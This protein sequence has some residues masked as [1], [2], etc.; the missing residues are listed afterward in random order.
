MGESED[1][2]VL[3]LTV[4]NR[5]VEATMVDN[6]TSRQFLGLLPLTVRMNDMLGR[7][8][9]GSGLP[10][11]LAHDSP[12]RT[13]YDVGELVYWPPTNGIAVYHDV[14]GTPVPEPGLIPLARVSEGVEV[15]DLSDGP[16]EVTIRVAE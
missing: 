7:E 14:A 16:A 11:Q 12:H 13:G 8:A 5:T 6:A 15:F 1:G 4:N 9:Y 3:S 2:V 10:E